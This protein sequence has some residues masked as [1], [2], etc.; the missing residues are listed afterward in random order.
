[1]RK[2]VC[3]AVVTVF[4]FSMAMADEMF[5][6]ITKID[7]NKITATKKGK[8]GAKGEAV[9]L[10]AAKDVRVVKGKFNKDTKKVEAGDAI[11]GGLKGITTGEKGV[12]A[13]VD[14]DGT[15]VKEIRVLSKKTKKKKDA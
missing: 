13:I 10:T 12:A 9:E 11:E 5:V 6:V 8:K 14:V 7:G 1:M 2:F 3:A 15:T 4:A